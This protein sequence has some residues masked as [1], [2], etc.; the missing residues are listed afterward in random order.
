MVYIMIF[1]ERLFWL[2]FCRRILVREM[3][4][5]DLA[6]DHNY[7]NKNRHQNQHGGKFRRQGHIK[8]TDREGGEHRGSMPAQKLGAVCRILFMLQQVPE[9][10]I[11]LGPQIAAELDAR[12][13]E[14]FN[15]LRDHAAVK[16]SDSADKTQGIDQ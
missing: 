6:D 8:S 13:F 2:L 15:D 11:L 1:M 7:E 10:F 14:I 3:P 9:N 5:D 4:S 12:V 16:P